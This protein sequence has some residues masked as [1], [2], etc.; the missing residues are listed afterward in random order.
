M[1]KRKSGTKKI[2]TF[3]G[4]SDEP[5]P[6]D[7]FHKWYHEA[8]EFK[9]FQP[10]A[11]HLSTAS[12]SGQPSGRMVLLKEVTG[13]GFVFFSNYLSFKGKELAL[14]PLVALTFHWKEMQASQNSR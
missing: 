8:M 14:N 13:K 5:H 9:V 2:N 6:I 1:T 7:L 11:M 3:T 12:I 10:D 4:L